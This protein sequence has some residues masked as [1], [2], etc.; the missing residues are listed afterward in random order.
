MKLRLMT[1][2]LELCDYTAQVSTTTKL[3]DGYV[4]NRKTLATALTS[5]GRV[6]KARI[7]LIEMHMVDLQTFGQGNLSLKTLLTFC[8]IFANAMAAVS[9]HP[10]NRPRT[11]CGRAT[12]CKV[13]VGRQDQVSRGQKDY[14]WAS[15]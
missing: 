5:Q 15:L 13:I 4:W 1:Q 3:Q 6:G 8:R 2:Q 14:G 11:G 12:P 10:L 9:L 7:T